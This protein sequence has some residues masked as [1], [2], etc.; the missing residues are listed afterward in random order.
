MTRESKLINWV[1][2][3]S[4]DE[5]QAFLDG[6]ET[7]MR[8][9]KALK[10]KLAQLQ[11]ERDV[12]AVKDYTTPVDKRKA[13]AEQSVDETLRAFTAR[14]RARH[15]QAAAINK[16]TANPDDSANAFG[17]AVLQTLADS[18]GDQVTKS[19]AASLEDDEVTKRIEKLEDERDRRY[20]R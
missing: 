17:F 12:A 5:L 3:A 15:E 9:N 20:R 11:A 16:Q 18:Q 19:V 4:S 1:H 8:N 14:L 10:E 6:V 7:L 2:T 13:E